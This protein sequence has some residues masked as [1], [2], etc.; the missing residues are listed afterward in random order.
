MLRRYDVANVVITNRNV[1]KSVKISFMHFFFFFFCTILD[2]CT[3]VLFIEHILLKL[4][5]KAFLNRKTIF[6][7]VFSCNFRTY[8]VDCR[9][10]SYNSIFKPY[11]IEI[12]MFVNKK[13]S[14]MSQCRACN[15]FLFNF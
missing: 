11:S 7:F 15:F 10:P 14:N 8:A 3:Y 9:L 5:N 12:S 1:S 13:P 6:S 2:I 4:E